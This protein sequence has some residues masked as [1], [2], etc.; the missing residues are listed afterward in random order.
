MSVIPVGVYLLKVNSGNTRTKCQIC[1]KFIF[2]VNFEHISHLVL[3][4]LSSNVNEVIRAV[5]NFF[6]KKISHTH[7]HTHTHTHAHTHTYTYMNLVV[8]TQ[9]RRNRAKNKKS[10]KNQS[11]KSIKSKKRK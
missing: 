3:V 6:Y 11:S 10:T 2:I 5:L 9:R 1:S 4:F 7:T 8:G